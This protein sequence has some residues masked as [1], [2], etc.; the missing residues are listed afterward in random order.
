MFSKK[1]LNL[2][3]KLK[4]FPSMTSEVT[5]HLMKNLRLHLLAFK[6]KK[7]VLKRIWPS[8]PVFREFCVWDVEEL[9]PVISPDISKFM[10][11][12]F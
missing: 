7:I 8:G 3:T 4:K 11:S 6:T 9:K 1:S 10:F 5:I 2:F 12:K